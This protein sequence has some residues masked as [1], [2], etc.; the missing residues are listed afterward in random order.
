MRRRLKRNVQKR[1]I[2]ERQ[3]ENGMKEERNIKKMEL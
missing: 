3:E 2:E 1:K